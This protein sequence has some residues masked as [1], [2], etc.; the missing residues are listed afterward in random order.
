MNR[1][2][3]PLEPKEHDVLLGR[4]RRHFRHHGNRRLRIAVGSHRSFY[5]R[6]TTTATQKYQLT[7][8]LVHFVKYCGI[9]RGRFLHKD[10][11]TNLWY[12]ADDDKARDSISSMFRYMVRS[13]GAERR[14][15]SPPHDTGEHVSNRASALDAIAAIA[16]QAAIM[17]E[18]MSNETFDDPD[19]QGRMEVDS[20]E[21]LQW[22]DLPV[23]GD[24]DDMPL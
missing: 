11:R 14:P 18:S 7:L 21:D 5:H 1:G 2:S 6:T 17:R 15:H 12:E 13:T 23:D 9:H 16:R 4:G 22:P 24:L 8:Q 20:Y 10:S 19:S 3:L